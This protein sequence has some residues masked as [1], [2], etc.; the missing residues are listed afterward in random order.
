MNTKGP[1]HYLVLNLESL[2]RDNRFAWSRDTK[3]AAH[4]SSTEEAE[5]VQGLVHDATGIVQIG[6]KWFVIKEGP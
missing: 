1:V 3:D 4:F 5:A 2:A 6:G